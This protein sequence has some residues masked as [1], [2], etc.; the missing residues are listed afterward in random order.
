MARQ[1]EARYAQNRGVESGKQAAASRTN[2]EPVVS[3]LASDPEMYELIG[4]FVAELPRRVGAMQELF[5]RSDWAQLRRAAHQLKGASGGYGF[6]DVGEVAGRV[7]QTL[8]TMRGASADGHESIGR[9]REQV[10]DLAEI[11][12]RVITG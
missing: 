11:C 2:G 8:N 6:P 10:D 4:L 9:L 7:E 12:G 1:R 5:A 3:R